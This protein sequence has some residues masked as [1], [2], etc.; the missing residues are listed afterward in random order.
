M[1]D[2]DKTKKA[3]DDESKHS[4]SFKINDDEKYLAVD[5]ETFL[6]ECGATTHIVNKGENF[7]DVDPSF[8]PQEHS[9]ELADGTRA[10][11]VAKKRTT[12]TISLRTING[13]VVQANL[14]KA[15]LIPTYP[16]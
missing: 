2:R 16:Q 3:V 11:N 4:S 15:L 13:H 6:V 9:I 7:I 5:N 8:K 1:K 10:N 12:V 14:E